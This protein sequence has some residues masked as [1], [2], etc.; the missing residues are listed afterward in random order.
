MRRLL[1]FVIV[2]ALA[3]AVVPTAAAQSSA[4]QDVT[5]NVPE[6]AVIGVSGGGV[7]FDFTSSDVTAGNSAATQT[8]QES[9]AL[10]TNASSV[11]VTGQL[12]AEYSTGIKLFVNLSA[13]SSAGTSQNQVELTTTEADLVTSIGPTAAGNIN[14]EYT[15]QITPEASPNTGSTE[16]VTYTITAN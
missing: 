15:A 13:P 14:L 9:Y 5:I 6:I 12:G 2:T 16:T 3:V 8:Q 4:T 1:T 10:F 7:T 11:K